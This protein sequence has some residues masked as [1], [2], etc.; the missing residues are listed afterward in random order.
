MSA[1]PDDRAKATVIISLIGLFCVSNCV[2][3]KEIYAFHSGESNSVMADGSM[4]FLRVGLS[5]D[6]VFQLLT[7]ARGEVIDA[8]F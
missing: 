6:V 2:N 8:K 5:L 7:R 1:R 3:D 4:R